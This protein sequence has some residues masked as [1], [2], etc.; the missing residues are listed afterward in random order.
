MSSGYGTMVNTNQSRPY[1]G[2]PYTNPTVIDVPSLD[3][4]HND[5]WANLPRKPMTTNKPT[6]DTSKETSRIQIEEDQPPT[7]DFVRETILYNPNKPN[8]DASR[9]TDDSRVQIDE[10]E[11]R[12]PTPDYVKETILYNPSK[13]VLSLDTARVQVEEEVQPPTPEFVRE[14]ILYNPFE[15]RTININSPSRDDNWESIANNRTQQ[16]R[17]SSDEDVTSIASTSSSEAEVPPRRYIPPMPRTPDYGGPSTTSNV[18]PVVPPFLSKEASVYQSTD[19][20]FALAPIPVSEFPEP[21]PAYSEI[22]RVQRPAPAV[23]EA[24]PQPP[25]TQVIVTTRGK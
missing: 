8:T 20:G 5:R 2:F 7:P 11:T 17:V 12:S 3:A 14:T 25:R 22:D 16:R 1:Q 6:L 9:D 13:P 24:V 21:P 4:S 10:E 18:T 23:P 19:D 15:D